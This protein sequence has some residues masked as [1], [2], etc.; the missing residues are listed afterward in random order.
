MWAA[1]ARAAPGLRL[2]RSDRI[3]P[4]A[5]RGSFTAT[6]TAGTDSNLQTLKAEAAAQA[7]LPVCPA[8]SPCHAVRAAAAVA[9]HL[10]GLAADGLADEPVLVVAAVESTGG[11]W[12]R[13]VDR[14]NRP[15]QGCAGGGRVAEAVVS[16]GQKQVGRRRRQGEVA[17]GPGGVKAVPAVGQEAD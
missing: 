17:A 2:A 9:N 7:A 5:W 4:S 6:R 3:C 16:H 10:F 8:A 11:G 13:V 15:G 1:L 14:L 12:G